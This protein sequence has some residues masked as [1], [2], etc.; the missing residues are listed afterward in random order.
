MLSKEEE[1]MGRITL[2]VILLAHVLPLLVMTIHAWL[3]PL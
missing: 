1:R 3:N 2:W